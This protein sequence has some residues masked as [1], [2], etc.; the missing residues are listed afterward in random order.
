MIREEGRLRMSSVPLYRI[1]RGM[2]EGNIS[3]GGKEDIS[4]SIVMQ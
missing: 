2:S 4:M 3:G 1:G